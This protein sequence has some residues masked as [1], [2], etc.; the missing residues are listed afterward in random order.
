MTRLFVVR[1]GQTDWNAAGRLQGSS[2][3]PL[4]DT[5]RGQARAAAASLWRVLEPDAVFVS[6]TLVRAAETARIIVGERGAP[7][8]Q[9]ARLGERRYG[10]WEG[11]LAHERA[12]QFPDDDAAWK[13]GFEPDFDGYESHVTVAARGTAAVHEWVARVP[14]DLVVVAH[15][16]SGRM[17][18]L[19][20]LGLAL[21]GRTLG[22]LENA[23][24]SR[25]VPSPAGGWS[26]ERHNV[27]APAVGV[28]P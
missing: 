11:L 16:S 18:M 14:G 6:S 20:L 23:A 13:A 24:W 9:D 19:S 12:E 17:L 28:R 26:L 15:G 1:H 21:E 22:N 7:L 4:N 10:P 25:L 2:D 27:G 8:H 5:G 3:I